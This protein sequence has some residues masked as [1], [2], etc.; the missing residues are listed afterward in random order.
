MHQL[1]VRC[2][3]SSAKYACSLPPKLDIATAALHLVDLLI[4]T[5]LRLTCCLMPPFIARL[6]GFLFSR[7]W[8]IVHGVP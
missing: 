8:P 2:S 5:I 1:R 3:C 4:Y 6:H 7:D